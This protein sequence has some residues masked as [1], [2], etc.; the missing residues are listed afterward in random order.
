MKR[1]LLF[2]GFL[3]M[4]VTVSFPQEALVSPEVHRDGRV[5]FRLLAPEAHEVKVSGDWMPSEGVWPCFGYT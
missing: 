2:I 5:T 1:I 4:A 3:V